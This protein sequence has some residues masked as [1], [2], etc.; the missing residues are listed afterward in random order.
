MATITLY[1]Y[2]FLDITSKILMYAF[3]WYFIAGYACFG[4]LLVDIVIATVLYWKTQNVEALLS[5]VA[6]PFFFGSEHFKG[7][8]HLYLLWN[9]AEVILINILIWI[10]YALVRDNVFN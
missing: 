5:V 6:Q 2:R 3:A 8:L 4:V 9:A 7:L 10:F 1:I